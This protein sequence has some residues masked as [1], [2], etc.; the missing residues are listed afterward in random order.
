MLQQNQSP[1]QYQYQAAR[2]SGQHVPPTN[3]PV[4]PQMGHV[5][6]P[7][8]SPTTGGLRVTPQVACK[9]QVAGGDQDVKLGTITG[10]WFQL[11]FFIIFFLHPWQLDDTNYIHLYQSDNFIFKDSNCL[12]PAGCLC[13]F[14]TWQWKTNHFQMIFQFK[15][16]LSLCHVWVTEGRFAH[17]QWFIIIPH[18]KVP[19]IPAHLFMS[20]LHIYELGGIQ[21]PTGL[22]RPRLRHPGAKCIRTGSSQSAL[23]AR[24]L[25]H[26]PLRIGWVSNN[27][28]T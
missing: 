28:V 4:R 5:A 19:T 7:L 10:C 12:K 1:S 9:D 21:Q 3:Q 22:E 13:P 11:P 20:S 24:C 16:G 6:P 23:F 8:S 25:D 27:K 18:L 2:Q 17:T 26:H 14:G 15:M